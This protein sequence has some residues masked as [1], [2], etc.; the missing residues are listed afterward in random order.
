MLMSFRLLL[1]SE[2][3]AV[4]LATHCLTRKAIISENDSA[5]LSGWL[6][7]T[8]VGSWLLFGELE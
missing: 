4:T 8:A 7:K 3:A 6:E 1:A 5:L 2:L